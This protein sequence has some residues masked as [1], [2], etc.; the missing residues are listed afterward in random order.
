M[1]INKT[2][3]KHLFSSV[4]VQ[5]CY[6]HLYRNVHYVFFVCKTNKKRH[7]VFVYRSECPFAPC[8]VSNDVKQCQNTTKKLTLNKYTQFL[9]TFS[10]C[11]VQYGFQSYWSSFSR[12]ESVSKSPSEAITS[13]RPGRQRQELNPYGRHMWPGLRTEHPPPRAISRGLSRHVLRVPKQ[14]RMAASERSTAEKR[15]TIRRTHIAKVFESIFCNQ[16]RYLSTF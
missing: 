5:I 3:N 4:I 11:S 6:I 9:Y 13:S 1:D 12:K 15:R 8:S 7:N 2:N 10:Q 14:S 16:R